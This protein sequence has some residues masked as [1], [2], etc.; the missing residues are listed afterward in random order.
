MIALKQDPADVL[1]TDIAMPN[2]DGYGLLEQLRDCGVDIPA[3]VLTG[4]A[5]E[6]DRHRALA[7]GFDAYLAKPVN[8]ALLVD[9]VATLANVPV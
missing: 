5:A 2:D 6:Q 3:A 4:L 8:P 9:T 7:A 1:L